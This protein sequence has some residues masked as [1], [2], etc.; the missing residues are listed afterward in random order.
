MT[1]GKAKKLIGYLLY[2]MLGSWLPHYQLGYKWPLT[3]LYR[4]I[5]ALLM[6][7]KCGKKVDIGRKIAFSSKISIGDNSGIGDSA[8]FIGEVHL[9]NN[10]MMGANCA[11][12]ASDHNH[13]NINIPMNKQGG[14]ESPIHIGN[15]VWIGHGVIILAGVNVGSGSIIAAGAVV[16]SDVPPY[17]VVGGVPAKI[18]KERS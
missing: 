11:F 4:R 9:G 10:V 6:F 16:T 1:V 7:D 12:I 3:T 8:F 15:D 17:T 18:I 2:N 13:S 5:C 14:S